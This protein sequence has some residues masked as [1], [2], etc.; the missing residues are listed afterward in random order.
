LDFSISIFKSR[1]LNDDRKQNIKINL[2]IEDNVPRKVFAFEMK[3]KQVLVNLLSN[4]YKFTNF[5]EVNLIAS[6]I[7]KN[8]KQYVRLS[9]QDTGF[10]ISDEEKERLFAPFKM[11]ESTGKNNEHGSGLGLMIVMDLLHSMNSKLEL[12]SKKNEGSTFY[13]DL[14]VPQNQIGYIN[15]QH[16]L[17]ELSYEHSSSMFDQTRIYTESMTNLIKYLNCGNSKIDQEKKE[18]DFV[19]IV[20]TIEEN[21]SIND[22][23]MKRIHIN[24]LIEN[25]I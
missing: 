1:L 17:G 13:F 14:D 10:G 8:D 16:T 9:V 25:V 7:I 20:E 22:N 21:N 23:F 3:L 15:S 5:G 18:K 11:L 4:A 19:I 12:I 24:D 2:R 6:S